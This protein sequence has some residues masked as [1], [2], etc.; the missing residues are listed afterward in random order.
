MDSVRALT[1]PGGWTERDVTVGDRTFHLLLPANPDAFIEE[2]N[3]AELPTLPKMR[4]DPFW[5]Q[6]WQAAEPLAKLVLAADWPGDT[7]VLELGCGSGLVGLAAL[8][9]GWRVTLSDYVPESVE[10]AVENARRNGFSDARGLVL[11][12]NEP[13][14]E[15]FRV[16]VASD[17]LYDRRNHAPLLKTLDRMLPD[18]GVVWIGDAG[19]SG[20]ADF[21][22]IAPQRG[23]SIEP[24]GADGRPLAGPV[25]ARF[26][27]FIVRRARTTGS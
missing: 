12:W 4:S 8:S 20:A 1:I 18:D 13:I 17:V 7:H 6:L 22:K 10:L 2:L 11:D 26:Q 14:A 16:M 25:N 21:F 24:R 15:S 23:Y 27:W 3:E 19:R 5:A 9:R